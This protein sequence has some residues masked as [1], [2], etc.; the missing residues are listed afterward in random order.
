MVPVNRRK[1]QCSYVLIV[2]GLALWCDFLGGLE[3]E[4][5]GTAAG[6]VE[7]FD[8]GFLPGDAPA[9]LPVRRMEELFQVETVIS[10]EQVDGA[11]VGQA[12]D[13]VNH[14]G[15]WFVLDRM[16]FGIYKFTE[17][18]AFVMRF[19]RRGEGPGEFEY[20]R[21]L[22]VC[23]DGLLAV[24]DPLQGRIQL[25]TTN[26]QF[27]RSVVPKVF[28]RLI[29]HTDNFLWNSRELLIV[30][31]W[32]AAKT[33]EFQWVAIDPD[34][35]NPPPKF[36]LGDFEFGARSSSD[37]PWQPSI[38]VAL[39]EIENRYWVG[40]ANSFQWKV[41]NRQGALVGKLG[42]AD[43]SV[44][45]PD[46]HPGRH[47]LLQIG[48]WVFVPVARGYDVY[49]KNGQRIAVNVELNSFHLDYGYKDRGVMIAPSG[50]DTNAMPDGDLKNLLLA[51][52]YR[53]QNNPFLVIFKLEYDRDLG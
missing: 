31:T 16:T 51:K 48:G 13:L 37:N 7:T 1:K 14:D 22:R 3:K 35:F 18:G 36:G 46:Q 4:R 33:S 5:S 24:N 45:A 21:R 11:N 42:S 10:L 9:L 27:V 49:L 43:E 50:L 15:H 28:Q 38:F 47:Q 26:G 29:S 23:F 52:G 30:Q 40:S 20:P 39:E 6:G 2:L 34:Q 12:T 41:F 17:D 32:R 19:G 8:S 53:P 44:P 25:F